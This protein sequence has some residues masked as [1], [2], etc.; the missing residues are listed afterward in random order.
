MG[1]IKGLVGGAVKHRCSTVGQR[2]VITR[3]RHRTEATENDKGKQKRES[4]KAGYDVQYKEGKPKDM[5][6]GESHNTTQAFQAKIQSVRCSLG[7]KSVNLKFPYYVKLSLP[8]FLSVQ[9]V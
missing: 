4:N 3:E 6:G 9:C 2:R 1:K 7:I 5:S 8:M